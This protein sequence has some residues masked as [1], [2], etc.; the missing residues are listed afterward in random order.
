MG[1]FSKTLRR[2]RHRPGPEVDLLSA[3]FGFPFHRGLKPSSNKSPGRMKI[4]YEPDSDSD[5]ASDSEATSSSSENYR[6]RQQYRPR[7]L[8]ERPPTPHRNS[9][10]SPGSS[11]K[12][13]ARRKQHRRR[14]SGASP[15]SSTRKS[16]RSRTA[17]S[18][19]RRSNAGSMSGQP[20]VPH[21][22]SSAT[23]P[24][25]IPIHLSRPSSIAQSKS[26]PISTLNQPFGIPVCQPMPQQQVFYRNP[27]QYGQP[28]PS[29][30]VQ[31]QTP[32]FMMPPTMPQPVMVQ[33]PPGLATV[34]V[35]AS[36]SD[37]N[38]VPSGSD[39]INLSKPASEAA[40]TSDLW[41]KE[42]KRLQKHIDAKMADLS[43]EPDSRVLR[44]DL[45]RLQDRLNFTLN[46][47]IS[48][49]KQSHSKQPSFTSVSNF[50]HSSLGEDTPR[51]IV[52]ASARDVVTP[53]NGTESKYHAQ[54]A[55]SPQRIPR[56]H[57][58]SGCGNIRSLQFHKRWPL[59]ET[60]KSSK[61]SYCES[62][63][64]EMYNRGIV[65]KYHFCFNCGGARSMAFHRQHPV[66]PG[67][68]IFVNYCGSCT[69]DLKV[70]E[71]LP[72]TSVVNMVRW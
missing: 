41:S 66:L 11:K 70:Y 71:R 42:I 3:A 12:S 48:H 40:D 30:M 10:A 5:D 7:Q 29:P 17:R 24:P 4:V 22:Q 13:P 44:R 69:E 32:Q 2:R 28:Q 65:Q 56:H 45:R 72:D 47:A 1:L 8:S 62:C 60:R 64:E 35:S 25:R 31:V 6:G 16:T 36:T 63:R 19:S 33:P 37:N 52:T 15:R 54:Q 38:T 68:P 50:S 46:K 51:T 20:H 49:S 61:I 67:E 59:D 43:S 55:R 21:V 26:F 23:F 58:C 9:L 14:R 39:G 53:V 34:P 57:V 27:I 18:T